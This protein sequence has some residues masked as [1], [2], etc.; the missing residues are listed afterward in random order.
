M[1]K[2]NAYPKDV[3]IWFRFLFSFSFKN[4]KCS[5]TPVRPYLWHSVRDSVVLLTVGLYPV[6]VYRIIRVCIPAAINGAISSRVEASRHS[7]L[8]LRR[9]SGLSLRPIH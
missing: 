1:L 7:Q 6:F 4:T 2:L 8:L 3:F 5:I 9:A